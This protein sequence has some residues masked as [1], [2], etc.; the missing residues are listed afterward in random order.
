MVEIKEQKLRA[1]QSARNEIVKFGIKYLEELEFGEFSSKEE[2]Q[3]FRWREV[4][5]DE[6]LSRFLVNASEEGFGWYELNYV[7]PVDCFKE[8]QANRYKL[9][10]LS[11]NCQR[12]ARSSYWY[13]VNENGFFTKLL[14]EPVL[15]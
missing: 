2:Y 6:M 14:I 8:F 7:L 12:T 13:T 11:S 5:V 3:E 9:Q 10:D 1:Y 15:N 4:V